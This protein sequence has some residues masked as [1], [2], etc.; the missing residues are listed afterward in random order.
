MNDKLGNTWIKTAMIKLKIFHHTF[1]GRIDD[2]HEEIL[3]IA[4]LPVENMTGTL[5][6]QNITVDHPL[7][8]NIYALNLNI[9]ICFYRNWAGI[10]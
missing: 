1:L 3:K 10:F 2:K 5:R 8:T 9:R 4:G 6:I 7:I